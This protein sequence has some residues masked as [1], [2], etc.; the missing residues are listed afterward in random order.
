MHKNR[1]NTLKERENNEKAKY[2]SFRKKLLLISVQ[3]LLSFNQGVVILAKTLIAGG[4]IQPGS[5]I[6]S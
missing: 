3:I 6:L 1:F 2:V 5:L 4:N